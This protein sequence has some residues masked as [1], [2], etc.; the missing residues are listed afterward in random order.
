MH[1]GSSRQPRYLIHFNNW[2]KK[3]VERKKGRSPLSLLPL[4]P[5]PPPPIYI[6]IY[7]HA[8]TPTPMHALLPLNNA[9]ALF[10]SS[11]PFLLL[12]ITISSTTS[13][14]FLR[15]DEWLDDVQVRPMSMSPKRPRNGKQSKTSEKCRRK[16]GK[17]CYLR[18]QREGSLGGGKYH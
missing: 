5:L 13:L 18:L 9:L 17:Y 10:S 4:P 2:G 7:I 14:L 3:L 1:E 12:P 11:F 8:R 16:R 15:Y 6:Y